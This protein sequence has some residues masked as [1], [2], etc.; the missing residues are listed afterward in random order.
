MTMHPGILL[1]I[2]LG[3]IAILCILFWPRRGLVNLWRSLHLNTRRTRI[4]HALKHMFN[5]EYIQQKTTVKSLSVKLS[6]SQRHTASLLARMESRGLVKKTRDGYG[7]TEEGNA[8]ALRIVR[9]HRL[10]E[11]YLAD[12]TGLRGDEWHRYAERLEHS[13]SPEQVEALADQLGQP[14]YDPHGAPIPSA[15]GVI[16]PPMGQPATAFATGDLIVVTRIDKEQEHLYSQIAAEGIVPGMQLR[17]LEMSPQRIRFSSQ[18]NEYVLAPVVASR[19][20]AIPLPAEKTEEICND[21]LSSLK[22]GET[23]KVVRFSPNCRGAERRRLMDLGIIPGT[24]IR[25][26]L[27]SPFGDPKAYFV[28]ETSIALRNKLADLIYIEKMKGAA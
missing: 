25:A 10:W 27:N 2:G 12:E 1:A 16:G 19:L 8:Y 9:A 22:I 23:G 3:V 4:E 21:T 6:I 11:R 7:L 26:D 13:T 20:M 15:D 28:R 17:I 5:N 24:L 14:L 18:Q